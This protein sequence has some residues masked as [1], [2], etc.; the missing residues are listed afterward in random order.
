MPP[1][2]WIVIQEFV[3]MLSKG[4]MEGN[5]FKVCCG[6]G[7]LENCN[8]TVLCGNTQMIAWWS[9]KICQL[10][11]LV[12]VQTQIKIFE[13]THKT[14]KK[15]KENKITIYQL[16]WLNTFYLILLVLCKCV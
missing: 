8:D 9:F 10:G 1:N 4:L 7:S 11:I 5:A 2:H 13:R 16:M 12:W 14:K 3:S 15:L 6:G